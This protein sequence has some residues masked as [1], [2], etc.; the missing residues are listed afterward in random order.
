MGNHTKFD[1]AK[2][3]PG[4]LE[5][6]MSELEHFTAP[7]K[8][9]YFLSQAFVSIAEDA[10]KLYYRAYAHRA[11]LRKFL[12]DHRVILKDGNKFY[13]DPERAKE[14]LFACQSKTAL[15]GP[16][17]AP[18]RLA[19]L[20]LLRKAA[21]T[22]PSQTDGQPSEPDIDNNVDETLDASETSR[23]D[24][25]E[26][27]AAPAAKEE[28]PVVLLK[29]VLFLT[30]IEMDVWTTL[31]ALAR[32]AHEDELRVAI[33]ADQEEFFLECAST[34]LGDCS[35]AVYAETITRFV[36]ARLIREFG[37][38]IEGKR[39]FR[40][41]VN[42]EAFHCIAID[43]RE[44]S[45]VEKAYLKL[46]GEIEEDVLGVH[47]VQGQATAR[48]MGHVKQNYPW[49]N[50]ETARLKLST[51]N[52]GNHA[53]GWGIL[54]RHEVS[55]RRLICWS[56]FE[57]YLFREK[58]ATENAEPAEIP[59]TPG[60][61]IQKWPEPP[62]FTHPAT[63]AAPAAVEPDASEPIDATETTNNDDQET[64]QMTTISDM[65]IAALKELQV[66][67]TA[68]LLRARKELERAQ[69]EVV[70]REEDL[71]Q[72]EDELKDRKLKQREML[73][74]QLEAERAHV[75]ALELELA[76]LDE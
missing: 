46:I 75:R 70:T 1:A 19:E 15:P 22:S 33:S 8:A 32:H 66:S 20:K 18:Q 38:V 45:F 59:S 34:T 58:K 7:K 28:R 43:A 10:E 25:D 23:S 50:A 41:L 55:G 35:P 9:G 63:L 73:A 27:A 61:A 60:T 37:K 48:L 40:F 13:V 71:K 42:W 56:G 26:T 21:P 5:R 24:E 36:G 53:T 11:G 16:K 74:G 67:Q 76:E 57:Q 52:K 47:L 62:V 4:A 17:A 29:H 6:V 49:L 51:Y 30:P 68:F 31:C 72:T 3:P 14:V 2:C 64:V 39:A 65:S 12:G 44:I 69:Q 54:L